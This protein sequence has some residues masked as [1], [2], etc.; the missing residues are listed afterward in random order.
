MLGAE[1]SEPELDHMA[2]LGKVGRSGFTPLATHG[3]IDEGVPARSA[4][5]LTKTG[6]PDPLEQV[7]N[8]KPVF[9]GR[10]SVREIQR[11]WDL[12]DELVNLSA[13]QTALGRDAGGE[14]SVGFTRR[15]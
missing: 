11:G 4:V 5:I 2:A 7:V 14:G 9:D 1:A 10:L 15:C 13:C 6:L 12:K 8:Q 3:M